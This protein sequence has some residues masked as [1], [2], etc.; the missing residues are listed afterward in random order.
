[1]EVSLVPK[2]DVDDAELR[3]STT[4]DEGTEIPGDA[5]IKL[6]KK[7]PDDSYSSEYINTEWSSCCM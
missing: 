3:D 2:E 4:D 7:L 5:Y 1:M 6:M